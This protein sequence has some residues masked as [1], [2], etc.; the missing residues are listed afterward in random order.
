[1]D[2]EERSRLRDLT[3]EIVVIGTG[4]SFFRAR[5]AFLVKETGPCDPDGDG[6]PMRTSF[7]AFGLGGSVRPN[8]TAEEK[9]HNKEKYAIPTYWGTFHLQL[10]LASPP[11]VLT[12]VSSD[13]LARTI[14]CPNIHK[15]RRKLPEVKSSR[16]YHSDH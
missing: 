4:D 1:M 2:R 13:V 3:C 8:A 12:T 5:R 14:M 9:R 7:D 15:P 11:E 6:R 16:S 10:S